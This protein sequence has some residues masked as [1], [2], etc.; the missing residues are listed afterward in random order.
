[1]CVCVCGGGFGE[2]EGVAL[3]VCVVTAA[4]GGGEDFLRLAA[5][6]PGAALQHFILDGARFRGIAAAPFVAEPSC[7]LVKRSDAEGGLGESVISSALWGV[8]V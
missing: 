5:F 2:R 1:M 3:V 8:C 7:N 4:P 6:A